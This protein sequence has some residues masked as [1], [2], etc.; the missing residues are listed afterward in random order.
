VAVDWEGVGEGKGEG[1]KNEG[2]G[3]GDGDGDE[4][5]MKG[6]STSAEAL[7]TSKRL[8]KGGILGDEM[9]LGK[10]LQMIALVACT[11][12]YTPPTPRRAPP[13]PPD[14]VWY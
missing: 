10:T 12:P 4:I 5:F 7:A 13:P 9:G 1:V 2:D 6:N 8:C 3:D 14:D 11:K